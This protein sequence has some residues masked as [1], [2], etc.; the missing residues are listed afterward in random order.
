MDGI[1]GYFT[2]GAL[3]AGAPLDV[4]Q[5]FDGAD[6]M[7]VAGVYVDEIKLWISLGWPS[8]RVLADN[9]GRDVL[10]G[11]H[12]HACV[13]WFS[14][15]GC[16]GDY[17]VCGGSCG[18]LV[19]GGREHAVVYVL[20]DSE[21]RIDVRGDACVFVHVHDGGHVTVENGGCGRVTVK[22][23]SAGCD[24]LTGGDVRYIDGVADGTAEYVSVGSAEI[25]ALRGKIGKKLW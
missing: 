23:H 21:V 20:D 13:E 15:G 17:V 7:G 6:E 9:I 3:K 8:G 16:D 2:I 25:E 24:V 5:R 14:D 4:V 22:V 11:M 10:S 1:G 12:V 19:F 18:E